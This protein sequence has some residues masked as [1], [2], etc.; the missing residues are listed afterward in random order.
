MLQ[1]TPTKHVS[2]AVS[3]TSARLALLSQKEQWVLFTSECPRPSYEELSRHH[4]NCN[5][6]VQIKPS[7]SLAEEEIVIKAIKAGTASA[8]IASDNL[9]EKSKHTIQFIAEQYHCEVFFI[10]KGMTSYTYH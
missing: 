1:V 9:S 10:P 5:R 7:L 6:I 3:L 8:V 2:S 4:I